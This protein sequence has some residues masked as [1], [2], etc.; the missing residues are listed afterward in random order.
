M[1]KIEVPEDIA[2]MLMT[3][4][5]EL[6]AEQ[7][8]AEFGAD[9]PAFAAFASD[10]LFAL[11]IGTR[12]EIEGYERRANKS[13]S[14]LPGIRMSRENTGSTYV[15]VHGGPFWLEGGGKVSGGQTVLGL[16]PD[17][18]MGIKVMNFERG[19]ARSYKVGW[20]FVAAFG[21]KITKSTMSSQLEMYLK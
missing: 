18:D 15:N 12:P 11:V 14:P 2:A 8:R 9:D 21:S 20:A 6:T 3:K 5:A 16:E 17:A 4:F 19:G 13:G 10:D 7:K 1:Q